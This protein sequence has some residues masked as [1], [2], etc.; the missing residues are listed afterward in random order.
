MGHGDAGGNILREKQLLNGHFIGPECINQLL[1]IPADLQ[2]AGG[3]GL[4]GG[5]GD[6]AILQHPQDAMV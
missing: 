1:H 3:Q 5:S 4:A 2:K 6:G